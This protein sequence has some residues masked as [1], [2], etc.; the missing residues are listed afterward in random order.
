MIDYSNPTLIRLRSI[1]RSIGI[2]RPAVLLYRHWF[3]SG[4]EHS[5]DSY[6]MAKIMPNDVVWDV[7]ANVGHLTEHF[8]NA[9]GPNG[10]VV[11]FEPSPTAQASLRQRFNDNTRSNLFIEALALGDSDGSVTFWH[12]SDVA[13]SVT[14]GM[15]HKEGAV[16]TSVDMVTGDNYLYLRPALAPN[17]VKIDVE[18]FESDVLTGMDA[19]LKVPQLRAIFVEIHFEHSERRGLAD[20]PNVVVN[21]LKKNGFSIAWV[22]PSHIAAER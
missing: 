1:G 8:L 18:G 14:D 2:L 7:G 20:A 11:A 5:F 4:Y 3:G 9:V 17:C 21:I 16:S 12:S 6:M 19:L 15:G 13:E 10:K 22:D